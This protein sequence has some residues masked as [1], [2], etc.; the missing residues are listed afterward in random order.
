MVLAYAKLII[1]KGY[2]WYE[3]ASIILTQL[4]ALV[5]KGAYSEMKSKR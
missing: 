3:K 1:D 2:L 5:H 4:S